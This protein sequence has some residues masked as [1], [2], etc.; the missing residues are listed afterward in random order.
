MLRQRLPSV[1][2][3]LRERLHNR[4]NPISPFPKACKSF[5]KTAE[6]RETLKREMQDLAD[7]RA[8]YLKG[9]VEEM[10]GAE[11]SLDQGIYRAVQEQ[12]SSAGLKYDAAAPAY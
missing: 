1:L 11:D 7:Q 8:T 9:R 5:V 3:L 10:G 4:F 2:R 12:A 6:R